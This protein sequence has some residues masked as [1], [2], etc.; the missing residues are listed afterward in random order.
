VNAPSENR[1]K[2]VERELRRQPRGAQRAVGEG[3]YMRLDQAGRRRFQFRR[4]RN[5]GAPG[6][7]YHSWLQIEVRSSGDRRIEVVAVA[8]AGEEAAIS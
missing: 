1:L 6:G 4:A 7:T 8:R 5:G 2:K 3:I